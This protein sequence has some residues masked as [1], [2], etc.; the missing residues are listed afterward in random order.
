MPLGHESLVVAIA[1]ATSLRGKDLTQWLEESGFPAGDIRLIDEEFVAGTLT[2]AGGEP[3]IVQGVDES[4]FE[5]ARFA[6]FAGSPAFAAK[7]GPS[8]DRAGATVIDLTGGLWAGSRALPWIPALDAVLPPPGDSGASIERNHVWVAP[9]TPAIVACSLSAALSDLSLSRLAI[10][11]LQPASERGQAGVTELEQQTIRLLSLQPIPQ[12]VFDTQVAF[13]LLGRWGQSSTE[14]LSA[15]RIAITR[16]VH[17]YLEGGAVIPALTLVQAPVFHAHG[18]SAY[19]EF[20]RPPAPEALAA[21]LGA[22]GFRIASGEEPGPS[23][24]A[25]AGE[26][27]LLISH[28][29]RDDNVASGYWFWGAADNFRVASVNAAR[30][31]ERFLAS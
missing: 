23:N 27:Q 3:A 22:V 12:D 30:I 29:E 9:S 28:A 8:A 2:E 24:L 4:S 11:F 25:V 19:A 17:Q 18:F 26:S 1:G 31:A 14:R 6:F 16:E 13:N 5:R 20:Q 15:A 10:V 21:R 7:H